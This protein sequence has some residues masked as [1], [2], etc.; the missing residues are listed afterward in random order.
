MTPGMHAPR[1]ML[2]TDG[3]RF[4]DRPHG[5]RDAPIRLNNPFPYRWENDLTIRAFEVVVAF[6]DVGA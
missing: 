1:D 2:P 3:R 5:H 6:P 4:L